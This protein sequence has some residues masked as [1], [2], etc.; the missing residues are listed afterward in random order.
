M[1]L[2]SMLDLTLAAPATTPVCVHM[3]SLTEAGLWSENTGQPSSNSK[4]FGTRAPLHPVV[5]V[6]AS[7]GN[8]WL[9]APAAGLMGWWRCCWSPAAQGTVWLFACVHRH[10]LGGDCLQAGVS[11]TSQWAALQQLQDEQF[12]GPEPRPFPVNPRDRQ[13]ADPPKSQL[14][15]L[16]P[17]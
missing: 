2:C 10:A 13:G 3:A 16:P 12:T 9:T 8:P 5:Q 11:G 7:L 17:P 4:N 14:V 1:R 6:R 15:V